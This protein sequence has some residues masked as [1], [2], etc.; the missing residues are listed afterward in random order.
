MVRLPEGMYILGAT[1]N[2]GR[3]EPWDSQEEFNRFRVGG[4]YKQ[5]VE[6]W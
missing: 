4:Q 5:G 3:L 6:I 1:L 2:L